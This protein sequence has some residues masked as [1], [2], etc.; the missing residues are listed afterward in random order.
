M[1]F[2][3]VCSLA[4]LGKVYPIHVLN[5]WKNPTK[6]VGKAP[7]SCD[8]FHVVQVAAIGCRRG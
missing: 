7:N 5:A 4:L 8:F 6:D 3:P 1:V 2:L